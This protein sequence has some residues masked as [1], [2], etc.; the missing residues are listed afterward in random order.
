MKTAMILLLSGI[1]LLAVAPSADA[2]SFDARCKLETTIDGDPISATGVADLSRGVIQRFAVRAFADLK[3]GNV[4]VVQATTRDGETFDVGSMS[5]LLRSAAMEMTSLRNGLSEVFPVENVK[6]VAIKRNGKVV[7]EG[8][9]RRFA[10]E[11]G[12]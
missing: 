8:K 1:V 12:R 3:D 9:C 7:A 10:S 5:M 2:R 11:P 6:A 4:L